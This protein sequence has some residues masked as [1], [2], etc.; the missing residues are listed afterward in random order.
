M[1]RTRFE[2]LA[3]P[4]LAAILLALTAFAIWTAVTTQTVARS[5]RTAVSLSDDY[6]QARYWV[7]AE[8][9]L[10]HQYR[11][12]PSRDVHAAHNAAA[13]ALVSALQAA[14]RIGS[15]DDQA[16]VD[17]VLLTHT[18]YLSAADDLFAAVDTRDQQ[19]VAYI[20][21]EETEP[22]FI[23]IEQQVDAA[24]T[25][26]RL[27][28]FQRLDALDRLQHTVVVATPIVF[29][30]GL[31]LLGVFAYIMRSYRRRI[32]EATQVELVRLEHAALTDHLTALGNH[33]AYQEDYHR[34][35]SRALRHDEPLTLA[36]IDI[37]EFKVIN[38]QH[39]HIHGDRVLSALA[40][41][42]HSAR[43]EDRAY[44]RGGDEFA[45][46]LP[47][48]TLPDARVVLERLRRDVQRHLCVT[49]VSIGVAALVPGQD[50]PTTLQEQAD[51]ALYEAKRH[52]RNTI[53]AFEEIRASASILPAAKAQA[54]RCLLA[55]G[56]V[57]VVFQPIWDIDRGAILAFEA[58][59]RPAPHYGFAGPQEAFDIA[60]QIGR[61]H[62][63]DALCCTAIL[64]R[65]AELPPTALLFLNISPR[66]LDLDTFAGTA[67]VDAVTAAGLSPA[68]VVLELT[69]RSMT[70][71][72]I[73][74]REA[75]R[76][77]AL[78][79]K[80]ALDDTGAGNAGLEMLSQLP[81]DYVKIDR[82]VLVKALT[83]RA[84]YAVMVGIIAIACEMGA[85][86]TAEGIED[87][88]VLTLARG[89]GVKSSNDQT[90]VQGLQ[91]YLLGR[92]SAVIPAPAVVADYRGYINAA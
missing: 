34:E 86:V 53:V 64:A 51:A 10:A 73:V 17:R 88:A 11:V 1:R 4:G 56:G 79:F 68:R 85:Y 42:L 58:L 41:L 90:G 5:A 83:D 32:D 47:N 44:R 49:T 45:L 60:E 6:Q 8:Q 77:R 57:S 28:A 55:E 30:L 61:A 91:G 72:D 67:L 13:R 20:D 46:V 70:S 92:P 69:E 40:A 2:R 24:A 18:G 19:R 43:A 27:E 31:L 54:L 35:V 23:L 39:G 29:A 71:L 25:I 75:A 21:D 7:G 22:V 14:R 15:A 65:A 50:D 38:D 9:S 76:L 37:D 84:A 78:G 66:T 3:S 16:L 48:T 81:V 89:A 33:R 26:H 62:D 36:L 82:G 80:L 87:T 74:V 59:T 63:L 52:G 12:D